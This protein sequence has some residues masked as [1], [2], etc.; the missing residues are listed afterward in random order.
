MYAWTEKAESRARE[1][2]LE[3]RKAGQPATCGY[4]EVG[5]QIAQAWLKSGYIEKVAAE[6]GRMDKINFNELCKDFNERKP[7]GQCKGLIPWFNVKL[8]DV[9]GDNSANDIL[10]QFLREKGYEYINDFNGYVWFLTDG[11]GSPWTRAQPEIKD[12]KVYFYWCK[13][14]D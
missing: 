3:E 6:S 14:E 7:R 4:K 13:F 11:P 8:D 12:G 1:I 2:G 5:G 10:R 9:D